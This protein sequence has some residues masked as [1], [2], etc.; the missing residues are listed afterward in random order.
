MNKKLLSLAI[1]VILTTILLIGCGQKEIKNDIVKQTPEQLAITTPQEHYDYTIHH[2]T[3]VENALSKLDDELSKLEDNEDKV[4]T[5]Q[6]KEY[7][8]DIKKLS[9]EYLNYENKMPQTKEADEYYKSAMLRL[10]N[11]VEVIEESVENGTYSQSLTGVAELMEV[12]G[13]TVKSQDNF[14][15]LGVDINSEVSN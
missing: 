7:V 6:A 14:E 2:Q 9:N 10:M 1:C 5:K 13:F 15:D 8:D 4:L 11:F 3:Q 12:M